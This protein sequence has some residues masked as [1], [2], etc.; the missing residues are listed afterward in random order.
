MNNKGPR[1]DYYV[2]KHLTQSTN[3]KNYN[4]QSK[5][6]YS[7]ESKSFKGYN[8][9]KNV[10][11]ANNKESNLNENFENK[12]IMYFIEGHRYIYYQAKDYYVDES[13][14]IYYYDKDYDGYYFYNQRK[15]VYEKCPVIIGQE[16]AKKKNS[17]SNY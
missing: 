8:N 2:S 14:N 5:N 7:S 9:N 15:N 13:N 17:K 16:D 12:T 11:Y 10:N 4:Q 3:N 1:Y 6:N